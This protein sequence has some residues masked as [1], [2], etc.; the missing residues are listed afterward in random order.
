M[1]S[2][3]TSRGTPP[4]ESTR[5]AAAAEEAAEGVAA[6]EAAG[7]GRTAADRRAV[8]ATGGLP[9]WRA[10]VREARAPIVPG[11]SV[12]KAAAVA[13]VAEEALVEAV[14]GPGD[15]VM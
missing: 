1:T 8:T 6:A 4:R 11:G 2:W 9:G 12:G 10:A 15:T 13:V 3:T 5:A 14:A 7:R